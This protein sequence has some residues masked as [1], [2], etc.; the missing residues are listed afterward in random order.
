[1]FE[2][3]R[4]TRPLRH[5]QPDHKMSKFVRP[6]NS[7]SALKA[8]KTLPFTLSAVAIVTV[9]FELKEL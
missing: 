8:K 9:D 7:R 3:G 6:L 2:S 4:K 1:M 5:F